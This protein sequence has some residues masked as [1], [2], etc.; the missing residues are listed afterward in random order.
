MNIVHRVFPVS[1]MKFSDVAVNCFTVQVLGP[2]QR[3][4]D[5]MVIPSESLG[6]VILSGLMDRERQTAVDIL[7]FSE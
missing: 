7:E 2:T 1:F 6:L 4:V 5:T 3:T